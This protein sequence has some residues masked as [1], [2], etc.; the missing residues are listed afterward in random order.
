M[1]SNALL[2]LLSLLLSLPSFITAQ[3]T[4]EPL[5]LNEA[6]DHVRP[7]VLP[8]F[9]GRAVYLTPSQPIRFS[10]TSNSSDGAFSV[11]QHSGKVSGWTP[12]RPHTHGHTHEH[13]YCARGRAELWG[14]RNVTGSSQEARLGTVGDYGS[15]PPGV[16]HTFQLVDPDSQMTHIFHPAGFEHLFE[17]FKPYE[18]DVFTPYPPTPEDA[19]P[20]GPLTPE[21][22]AHLK[23]LDLY[24][25]SSD[26]FIPRRDMVNG[27]AGDPTLNWHNGNNTL[28]DSAVDPYY[29]ANNYGPKYLNTEAGYKVIQPLATPQQT[30]GTGNFTM[31]TVIM[32][33]KLDADPISEA[34]LPHHFAL[35]MEDGQLVLEIDGYPPA[36]LL[37]GDVAFIPAETAFKYY[38]T[39]PMTKFLY[40]NAGREGLE[41]QLLQKSVP[42]GFPAFPQ[43]AGFQG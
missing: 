16:I 7:Y 5:I 15:M 28:P 42:W 18:S 37:A 33:A 1:K 8:R 31:G 43:D 41:Y 36:S 21:Y 17:E 19:E 24:A 13:F 34:M 20:F 32:S 10:I 27:T 3:T 35:Q 38:A 29:I 39:V 40:M 6:P 23:S 2:P 9:K 12:A 22:D 26:I 25:V 11:L 4:N 30:S 14:Q